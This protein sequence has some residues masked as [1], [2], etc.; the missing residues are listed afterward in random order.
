MNTVTPFPSTNRDGVH[1]RG[2]I[3]AYA[4]IIPLACT[5]SLFVEGNGV[6]VFI[7]AGMIL[8]MATFSHVYLVQKLEIAIK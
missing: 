1:A 6:T 5:P 7:T 8:W 2:M 3:I 4:I